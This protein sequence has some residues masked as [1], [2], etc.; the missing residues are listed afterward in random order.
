MTRASALRPTCLSACGIVPHAA[1]F[2]YPRAGECDQVTLVPVRPSVL[3]DFWLKIL[4]DRP[5]DALGPS[6]HVG[7]RYALMVVQY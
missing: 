4:P 6:A 5:A 1:S 7:F 3:D 2:Y